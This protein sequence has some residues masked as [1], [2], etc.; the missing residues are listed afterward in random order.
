M[1]SLIPETGE[2]H[3]SARP[4]A[5]FAILHPRSL[6]MITRW[7]TRCR[8]AGGSSGDNSIDKHKEMAVMLVMDLS[9][10]SLLLIQCP[11]SP[12]VYNTPPP[13]YSPIDPHPE[14]MLAHY[15]TITASTAELTLSNPQLLTTPVAVPQQDMV[16]QEYIS[17][18]CMGERDERGRVRESE[19]EWMERRERDMR[20]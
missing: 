18:F 5:K 19:S 2:H 4:A 1:I 6:W 16:I 9:G 10:I 17:S 12:S 15:P 8:D 3:L 11:P 20:I 14:L 7:S 13:P